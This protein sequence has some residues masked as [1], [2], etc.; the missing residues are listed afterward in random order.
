[1]Q[2]WRL[3]LG[4]RTPGTAPRSSATWNTAPW[5][6]KQKA[7]LDAQSS[8]LFAEAAYALG[9]RSLEL[10]P[11]RRAG[12]RYVVSDDF[13]ERGSAAALEGGDDNLDAAFHHLWACA[14]NGI[15][16]WMPNAA[17]RS[18]APSAGATT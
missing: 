10:E 17:W 3:S 7:K 4:A 6:A 13:R 8:Q 18:P 5:P 12:L 11:L 9:W 15:S 16:S 2:Q 14:R 1:M